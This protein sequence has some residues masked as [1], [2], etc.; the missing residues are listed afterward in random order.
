[1]RLL[2]EMCEVQLQD[3]VVKL[4]NQTQ[5]LRNSLIRIKRCIET[6]DTTY[7]LAIILQTLEATREES[8]ETSV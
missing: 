2:E 6:D 3:E 4:R 5:W 8:N 1:M 7:A